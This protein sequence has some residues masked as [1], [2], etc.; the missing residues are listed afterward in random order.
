MKSSDRMFSRSVSLHVIALRRS[1]LYLQPD[2]NL[3][4]M[5]FMRPRATFA[6]ISSIVASM[7]RRHHSACCDMVGS[8]RISPFFRNLSI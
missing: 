4:A 7:S 1:L 3:G 5:L 2:R 8:G 6:P